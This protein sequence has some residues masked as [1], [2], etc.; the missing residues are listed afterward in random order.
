MKS[1][2]IC[3]S[4]S[5]IN[6][7]LKQTFNRH[8]FLHFEWLVLFG[9]LLFTAIINPAAAGISLCPTEWIG[10]PF[11][12]GEGLGRSMSLFLRGEFA[13][14]F[15]MH[16][17]GLFAVPVMTARIGSIWYRNYQLIKQST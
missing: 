6:T 16:P 17:A 15:R 1:V 13:A 7:L 10:I 8:L 9:A 12:P 3:Q 5:K 14:S 4:S 2:K 11:C